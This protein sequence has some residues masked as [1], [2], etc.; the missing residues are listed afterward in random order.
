MQHIEREEPSQ[1]NSNT[2]ISYICHSF[3]LCSSLLSFLTTGS[4]EEGSVGLK[5]PQDESWVYTIIIG[6]FPSF[7]YL[8]ITLYI[9]AGFV[10]K[11]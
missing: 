2:Y 8:Q 5:I 6:L 4:T 7:P 1:I 10:Y 3:I 9:P 11:T